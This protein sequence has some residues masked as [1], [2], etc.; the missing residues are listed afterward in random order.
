M[1]LG[2]SDL[3]GEV[4]ILQGARLILFALWDTIWDL[5]VE[6]LIVTVK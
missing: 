3:I 2:K 5:L 1:G 6:S 4:T